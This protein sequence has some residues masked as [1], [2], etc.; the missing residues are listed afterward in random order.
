L[1]YLFAVLLH[2][3]QK[4]LI[5]IVSLIYILAL[6]ADTHFYQIIILMSWSRWAATRGDYWAKS[7][8]TKQH[9]VR[10]F[11]A[12]FFYSAGLFGKME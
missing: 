3:F 2:Y 1:Q 8:Q 7:I 4:I 11:A 9:P 10:F 6:Q 5:S 12:N